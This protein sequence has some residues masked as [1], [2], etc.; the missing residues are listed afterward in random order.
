MVRRPIESYQSFL[1]RCWYTPAGQAGE[2]PAW[3][4][5][6]RDVSAEPQEHAFRTLEQ[7][8]AF[9]SAEFQQTNDLSHQNNS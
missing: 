7:M 4:I 2:P 5:S 3:R 1:L 8:I 6:L 9:V